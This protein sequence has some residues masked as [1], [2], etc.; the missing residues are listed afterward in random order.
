M[1]KEVVIISD[2]SESSEGTFAATA[3]VEA[4][5]SCYFHI[6]F[7]SRTLQISHVKASFL[8]KNLCSWKIMS[9]RKSLVKKIKKW[10]RLKEEKKNQSVK[11][12]K[13]L[14]LWKRLVLA[15]L[16]AGVQSLNKEVAVKSKF[17]IH[18]VKNEVSLSL[19][20]YQPW[21]K[22]ICIQD[23]CLESQFWKLYVDSL[24]RFSAHFAVF[25]FLSRVFSLHWQLCSSLCRP[26]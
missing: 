7:T 24:S 6:L 14:P 23:T 9:G 17:T 20:K 12:R 2:L 4:R 25:P 15:E 18:N 8:R 5:F 13:K 11:K 21:C 3:H 10:N 16:H 26:P 1:N 19:C 22:N